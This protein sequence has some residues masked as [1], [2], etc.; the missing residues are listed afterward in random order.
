MQTEIPSRES[1]DTLVVIPT[2]VS[3]SNG[4][5]AIPDAVSTEPP[6]IMIV[7]DE[8]IN[9]KVT[10]K[11]LSGAGYER[12]V[13]THDDTQ[14]F[15]IICEE[16]PDIVLLD[17][18]MPN[19]SGLD[20]LHQLRA[21]NRTKNLPVLILTASTDRETRLVALQRGA[22]DFLAKPVDPSELV[23][24]VR[25]ALVVKAHQDHLQRYAQQ[26]EDEVRQRTSEL[27][28]SR[29]EIIEC[30]ARAAEYRDGTTGKHIVR[31]GRYAAAVARQ[32]GLAPDHVD[33]IEQA[34]QLH[35]VGK[36]G[37][38]DDILRKNGKLDFEEFALMKRHCV[39]GQKILQRIT[40]EEF[41]KIQAEGGSAQLLKNRS[42]S[43]VELAA[44]IALTHHEW[45]DGSGYPSGLAG[46]EIPI[47]GRITSI[48][49]VYDALSSPRSYK[50]AFN[51]EACL[52][53][54]NE[55]RGS[56]FEPRIVDAFLEVIDDLDAAREALVD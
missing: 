40:D 27:E 39:Y 44:R 52:A 23:P 6:K 11:Y 18:V 22:T 37:I 36:I 1:S 33:L 19:V 28:F 48:A 51:K 16:L 7:D 49:D 8:P 45:W 14:A 54:I 47:E 21:D 35:D 12:F 41:E 56:Q 32:L 50:P 29:R 17:V 5:S 53:I 34:S 30:L 4:L 26:L 13:I 15:S 43:L 3:A 31:V 46:E 42:S 20:I 55:R 25:N 24:R 2:R 38:P 9:L 10:K